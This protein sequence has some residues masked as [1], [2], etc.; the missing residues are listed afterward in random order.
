MTSKQSNL[1]GS[2]KNTSFNS[3]L[4]ESLMN[5]FCCLRKT[6]MSSIIPLQSNIL[7]GIFINK[8]SC[9]IHEQGKLLAKELSILE[10]I[11][12]VGLI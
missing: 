12:V 4:Q 5:G 1:R 9:K 10:D 7:S 2:R 3:K 11:A 8:K 6:L